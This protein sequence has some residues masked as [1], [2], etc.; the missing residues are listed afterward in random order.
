MFWLSRSVCLIMS[1]RLSTPPEALAE[2]VLLRD[3]PFLRP[4]DLAFFFFFFR[5]P[6]AG[7]SP[8]IWRALPTARPAIVS[9]ALL[10]ASRRH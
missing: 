6:L 3:E 10:P 4:R 9:P 1:T 5:P 8:R 2:R 7:A